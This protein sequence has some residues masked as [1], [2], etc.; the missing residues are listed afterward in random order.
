MNGVGDGAGDE[1]RTDLD[2]HANM[3]AVGSGALVLVEHLW[4]TTALV[5][6]APLPQTMSL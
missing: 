1:A 2:S 4:N 3:P 5:T 6:S